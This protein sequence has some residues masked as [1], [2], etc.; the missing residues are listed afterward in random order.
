MSL[1]FKYSSYCLVCIGNLVLL[2]ATFNMQ[3]ISFSMYWKSRP[4]IYTPVI[5]VATWIIIYVA[6]FQI[7]SILFSVTPKNFQAPFFGIYPPKKPFTREIFPSPE[8]FCLYQRLHPLIYTPVI[9][10]ATWIIIHVGTF[11]IQFISF[12]MYWKSRPLTCY[13]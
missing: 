11:Q 12:S 6:T 4:L 5:H 3:C 10:V 7:Q 1:H 8:L 2:H 9:H 13:I